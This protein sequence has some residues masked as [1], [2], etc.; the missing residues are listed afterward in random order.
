M[1]TVPPLWVEPGTADA[2]VVSLTLPEG[3]LVVKPS[4]SGG[5]YRTARYEPHEHP[6]ARAHVAEL[7][8]S[9]RTANGAAL[10]APGRRRR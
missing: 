1:P 3:E 9:G 4:V 6:A 7:I 10:R 2:D 8:D 5:G